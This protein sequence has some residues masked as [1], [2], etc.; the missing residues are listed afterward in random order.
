M[1]SAEVSCCAAAAGCVLCLHDGCRK[2]AATTVGTAAV[3]T[4]DLGRRRLSGQS[5]GA[6]SSVL[7]DAGSNPLRYSRR[8]KEKK[9]GDPFRTGLDA[10]RGEADPPAAAAAAASV[11]RLC[12]TP[13]GSVRL[14]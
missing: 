4:G 10:R 3:S 5:D 9:K 6:T 13:D 1:T 14:T 11:A 2:A 12:C 7:D 8:K